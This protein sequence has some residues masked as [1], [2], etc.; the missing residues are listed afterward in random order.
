MRLR[1][2]N[3][4]KRMRRTKNCKLLGPSVR[5]VDVV[6]RRIKQWR[7]G[8]PPAPCP[9]V[10]TAPT[11]SAWYLD[12]AGHP[13]VRHYRVRRIRRIHQ[14]ATTEPPP[15]LSVVW[16]CLIWKRRQRAL[17]LGLMEAERLPDARIYWA[18]DHR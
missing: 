17:G 3:A 8:Q 9:I 1:I 11:C 13:L 18:Q 7:R 2:K 6:G 10:V 5:C 14:C 15:P 16:P 4:Q 12:G